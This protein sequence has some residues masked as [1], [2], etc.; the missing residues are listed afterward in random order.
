MLQ[1]VLLAIGKLNYADA[2]PHLM[3]VLDHPRIT[4]AEKAMIALYQITGLRNTTKQAWLD[5][6]RNAYQR[7]KKT[8]GRR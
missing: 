3:K 6:Y 7:W 2:I 1:A 8:R 5:W 4:T